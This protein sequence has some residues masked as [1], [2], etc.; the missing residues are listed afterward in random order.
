MNEF[1]HLF[2]NRCTDGKYL[3][4]TLPWLREVVKQ[5]P[6]V[7]FYHLYAFCFLGTN[8]GASCQID[9]GDFLK[10]KD[11]KQKACDKGI[12]LYVPC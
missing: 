7:L 3:F 8:S 10:R 6:L 12:P 1:W 5:M 9:L 11:K 4:D 2:K